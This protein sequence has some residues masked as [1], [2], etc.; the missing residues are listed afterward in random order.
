MD[1]L[2][3][4]KQT[5]EISPVVDNKPSTEK[6]AHT[7]KDN[8]TP[9]EIVESGANTTVIWRNPYPQGTPEARKA[10]LEV[11]IESMLY[12]F[13]S[14]DNEQT[15]RINNMVRYVLTGR[16]KLAELRRLLGDGCIEWIPRKNDTTANNSGTMSSLC[17]GQLQGGLDL[18]R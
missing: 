11:V 12:G 18:R 4:L 13:L 7:P 8:P 17:W 9:A 2:N 6:I 15:R 3:R 16:A 5:T 1:W 14:V 10:S